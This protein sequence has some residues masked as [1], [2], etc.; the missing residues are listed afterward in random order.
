[1]SWSISIRDEE[2]TSLQAHLFPGDCD[3]HAAFLFAGVHRA[4]RDRL[5][6]RRVV[7]VPDADFGPSQR[8]AYRAIS[9]RAV[10]R[11][12]RKCDEEGLCLLWTHSHPGSDTIAGFSRD[13][14]ESHERAHPSLID[15]THGRPVGSVVF[16]EES[17]AG[18]VWLADGTIS[19][20]EFVRVVGSHIRDLT[21][22][23]RQSEEPAD[24]FARQV[25]LFGKEGQAV[26][27]R[28]TV[29]V[30][31]AGGGG[32]LIVQSLPH[33]GIGR[34]IVIDFDTVSNANLSRLV[35]AG[36]MDVGRLKIDVLRDMVVHRPG[37]GIRRD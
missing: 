25:L 29:A 2:Y 24:R 18:E 26:L 14:R 7:P 27:K 4:S 1:M 31:G 13:D 19:E 35:G 33:L 12:A 34:L 10:A 11:A 37:C 6:V 21:P 9:A 17:A 3:E 20:T 32:S 23:K 15:M 5:L 8:G 30:A 22:R 28:M 16:G 36:P